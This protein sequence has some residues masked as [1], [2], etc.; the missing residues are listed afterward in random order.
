MILCESY[1]QYNHAPTVIRHGYVYTG[2]SIIYISYR[3]LF[4]IVVHV[5]SQIREHDSNRKFP[6]FQFNTFFYEH[7]CLFK[8]IMRLLGERLSKAG[9]ISLFYINTNSRVVVIQCSWLF[10]L[11]LLL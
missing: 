10:L 3:K 11:S 7:D 2:K 1:C 9:G 5:Y 4:T 6:F 8:I